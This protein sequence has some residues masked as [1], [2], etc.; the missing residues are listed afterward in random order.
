[1]STSALRPCQNYP[2]VSTR[3]PVTATHPST[4]S[5]SP[6]LSRENSYQLSTKNVLRALKPAL[7]SRLAGQAVN[8]S[9]SFMDTFCRA[10]PCQGGSCVSRP[11]TPSVAAP[12]A[13]EHLPL[14]SG[15]PGRLSVLCSALQP[16]RT[17]PLPA[18]SAEANGL[19]VQPWTCII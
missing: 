11:R 17:T 10:S 2:T 15:S 5:T 8:I 16:R 9:K 14:G 18:G 7:L 19:Q 12:G 3:T 13:V 1:M 6:F 4:C